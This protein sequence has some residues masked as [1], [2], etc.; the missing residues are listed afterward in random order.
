MSRTDKTDPWFVKL[1]REGVEYH[2]HSLGVC[3]FD[4]DFYKH[5]HDRLSRWRNR[6]G[7]EQSDWSYTKNPWFD[8]PKAVRQ[9]SKRQNRSERRRVRQDI[10]HGRYDALVKQGTGRN[11]AEWVCY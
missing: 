4:R 3:D 7:L 5:D 8:Q 11:N 9:E 1:H 10:H 2:D 6:C